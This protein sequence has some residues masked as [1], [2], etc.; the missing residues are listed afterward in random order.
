MRR[1]PAP[2]KVW[3]GDIVLVAHGNLPEALKSYRE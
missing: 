3:F 1:V 2:S